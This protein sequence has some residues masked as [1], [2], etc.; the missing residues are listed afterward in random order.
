MPVEFRQL[1]IPGQ[2]FLEVKNPSEHENDREDPGGGGGSQGE[3]E[4]FRFLHRVNTRWALLQ[5]E[6][7]F[8]SV[9]WK[10]WRTDLGHMTQGSD[11]F[12]SCG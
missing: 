10:L 2:T 8:P 6:T 11:R 5:H 7:K 4:L 1:S 9:D 12:V 3:E